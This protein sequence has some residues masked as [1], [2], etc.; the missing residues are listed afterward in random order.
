METLTDHLLADQMRLQHPKV[1][2][3]SAHNETQ[4][5]LRPRNIASSD[6]Q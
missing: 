4:N 6:K 1:Q 2:T 3:I 5:V